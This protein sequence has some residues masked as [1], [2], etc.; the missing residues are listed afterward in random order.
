MSLTRWLSTLGIFR[1]LLVGV[2]ALCGLLFTGTAYAVDCAQWL[3]V[4]EW[5]ADMTI[6]G[7]GQK[8]VNEPGDAQT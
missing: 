4:K 7:Q 5:R 3:A 1:T 8:N 6:S 2:I